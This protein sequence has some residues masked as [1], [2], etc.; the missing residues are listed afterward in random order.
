MFLFINYINKDI[1]NVSNFRW[2]IAALSVLY[3]AC[4]ITVLTLHG[5]SNIISARSSHFKIKE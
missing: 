4:D 3:Q 1:W 2:P 5:Y